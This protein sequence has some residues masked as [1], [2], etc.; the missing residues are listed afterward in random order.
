MAGYKLTKIEHK[1]IVTFNEVRCAVTMSR[2]FNPNTDEVISQL[3]NDAKLTTLQR[4]RISTSKY[5]EGFD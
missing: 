5:K 2:K 3:M 4:K 1:E